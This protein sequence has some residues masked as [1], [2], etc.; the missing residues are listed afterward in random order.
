MILVQV[1]GKLSVAELS[2]KIGNRQLVESGL[3]ELEA[4]G[5][6]APTMEGVSVWEEGVRKARD[7]PAVPFSEFSTFGPADALSIDKSYSQAMA[8]SF[9]TFGKATQSRKPSSDEG[10]KRLE[11][12]PEPIF[13][14]QK[15]FVADRK[16][17]PWVRLLLAG[18]LGV[19]LFGFLGLIFYPYNNLRPRI[20]A[21]SSRYLQTPVLVGS[22]QLQLVPRPALILSNLK[23][24]EKGDSSLERVSLPPL[25]LLRSGQL[26]IE[27]VDI[28]GASFVVD[29]LLKFPGFGL[30]ARNADSPIAVKR[31]VIDRL[32]MIA[33]DLVV[34]GLQGE[35][36]NGSDGLAK[37]VEFQTVDRNIR[38]SAV[39]APSGLLLN[40][41][42]F[43]WKP[44]PNALISFDSL[45]AKGL[46]QSGKLIVQSFDT[47]FLGGIV[48]GSW[49]LDW[50]KGLTMA[51][52]ASLARLDARRIATAFVPKLAME[53][54]VS[55]V[56]RLRGSGVSSSAM[57]RAADGSID[58][59]V[60]NG[61]VYGVDL[62]EAMRRGTGSTVRGGVTKFERLT[63]I[64]NITE[65]KV[66]GRVT[67]LDAGM[68]LANGQF[69]VMNQ[70]VDAAMTVTMQTSVS[71]QRLPVKVS[72]IIPDL[73]SMAGR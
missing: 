36:S 69:S 13:V 9:S 57:W 31:F 50:S 27:R 47:T 60:T 15:T 70:R 5:Y 43:G 64:L 24:G 59:T 55:G 7:Q 56:L 35:I 30:T 2:L 3:R 49:L 28:S 1:D 46:L 20:E 34:D 73:S 54:E 71:S 72:G 23:I 14:E 21:A 52:D 65:G 38:F 25:S 32:S 62:G 66:L 39:P 42:G 18:G 26:E 51:G 67:Q 58:M 10:F 4:D 63:G 37:K 29:H 16:P 11:K 17:L 68:M 48:K 22:V 6:I 61:A 41:E 8:S 12:K 44:F 53:G 45:Q 19:L 33:G 40:I